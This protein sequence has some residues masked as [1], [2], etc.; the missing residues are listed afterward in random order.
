MPASEGD[1]VS[2]REFNQFL[3]TY[4]QL[5]RRVE[6][7][8]TNGTRGVAVLNL[9]VTNLI[10]QI[11]TLETDMRTWQSAHVQA[12]NNEVNKRVSSRRWAIGTAIA[13]IA[14]LVALITMVGALLANH[15]L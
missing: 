1:P 14:A 9:Q 3:N 4:N 2:W 6:Q 5:A 13:C 11:A 10:G 8:D 15:P 7:M 12:H